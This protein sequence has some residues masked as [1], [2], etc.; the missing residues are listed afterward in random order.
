MK[1]PGSLSVHLQN[2]VPALPHPGRGAAKLGHLHPHTLGQHG[3]R[4]PEG[5]IFQFHHIVDGAAPLAAAEAL[6][7]L[8]VGHH[9]KGGG[10]F[11]VEGTAA[12]VAVSLFGQPYCLRHQVYN[13]GPSQQLVQKSIG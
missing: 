4:I 12:P 2:L 11:A 7:H 8:A 9:M 5:Q 1:G 6:V 13:V 10:L 3:H